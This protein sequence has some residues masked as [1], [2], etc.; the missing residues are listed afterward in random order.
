MTLSSL[1]SC[2]KRLRT[3]HQPAFASAPD[4]T[5]DFADAIPPPEEI[6]VVRIPFRLLEQFDRTQ[7]AFHRFL[8]GNIFTVAKR[9]RFT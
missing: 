5:V 7:Q 8:S 6:V 2:A 1:Y 4:D 3:L 9:V